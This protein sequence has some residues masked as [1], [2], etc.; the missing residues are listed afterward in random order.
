M[1]KYS[2]KRPFTVLVAVLIISILGFVAVSGMPADLLPPISLPY[3][4]VI[5]PYP[6]A[7]C[8]RV[9]QFVAQ[10]MER[11]LGTISGVKNIYSNCSENYCVIQLELED[12]VDMDASMVKISGAV[13]Q[14]EATLPDECGTPSILE[15]SMDMLATMYVA[16]SREGYDIYELSAFAEQTFAPY[17][18]RTQGVA[19]VTAIGLVEKSV[20]VDLDA[21]KVREVN[22]RVHRDMEQTLKETGDKLDEALEKVEDGQRSLEWQERNF[23][24]TLAGAITEQ[25]GEPVAQ[26]QSELVNGIRR[27]IEALDRTEVAIDDA[28]SADMRGTARGTLQETLELLA[29]AAAGD[30]VAL[31]E[32]MTRLQI[33]TEQVRAFNE[34]IEQQ[35]EYGIRQLP[36]RFEE[37]RSA[38]R[39]L[40]GTT[41]RIPEA[42][43]SAATITGALTQGQLDAAVGFST[44]LSQMTQLQQ[45]LKNA[46]AQYESAREQ[47][48]DNANV[49]GLINVQ[50]LSQIL[51]AQNFSMPAGYIDDKNDHSWLLKVGTEFENEKEIGDLLLVDAEGIGQIRLRDVAQVTVIDN[52]DLSYTRLNGQE[53]VALSIYKSSVAGTNEV[54]RALRKA[55]A[56]FERSYPG[57]HVVNLMDQGSYIDLIVADILKS[58]GFG[59]I[60]AIIVLA[61]FLRDVRPT[62]MVAVSIPLSVL[63]TMVLMYF[64]NLSLNIMTLSGISLGIGMLVDNSIVVMENII[65]LR[66]RGLGAAT[67]AVQGARQVF[68]A[69][70]ASTLTTVCVFV[71]MVFATG[72]VRSLLIPMALSITYCLTASLL[73]AMT[74][75]PA[76]ASVIM[77]RE[78]NGKETLFDKVKNAYAKSLRFCLRVKAIPLML[79]VGLLAFSVAAV[80]RM[81]IIMIPEITSDEIQ[82]DYTTPQGLTREESFAAVDELMEELMKIDGIQDIGFLDSS[83]GTAFFSSAA[84]RSGSYGTYLGYITT[85]EGLDTKEIARIVKEIEDT[86]AHMSGSVN[87]ETGGAG[88]IGSFTSS[89]LTISVYGIELDELYRIAKETAACVERIKGFEDIHDG[90]GNDEKA[91]QLVIDRDKAM[92]CGLTVAQ[93]Y[94]QIASRMQT[95]ADATTISSDNLT[96]TVRVNDE[97]NPLSRENLLDMEFESADVPGG[98]AAYG[99][100]GQS[101]SL[102]AFDGLFEEAEEKEEDADGEAGEAENKAAVHKLSEFASLRETTSPARIVRKNQTRYLTVSAR[103]GEGYNTTLLSRELEKELEQLNASLPNGYSVEMEGEILE[104]AEMIAQMTKLLLLAFLFIYLVMVAQFQ[105]LLSPFIIIFT[106]PLAF[107]GGMI[108]LLLFREQLSVLSLMG[109]LVLMGTVVNN[110]IVYVDYANQLR[111]GG[112]KRRD[113]L[114]ATGKT[115]MRPIIMTALTTVLA[116]TQL[117]FGTGMGAQLSRGMAIVIAGGLVYA[118]FMTLYIVPVMYDILFRR[119]PLD[120]NIHEDLDKIPDDAAAYLAE[121]KAKSDE[122][123][124]IDGFDGKA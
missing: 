10:P 122:L 5:T 31:M 2:V 43:S 34:R 75:V 113:A 58:M 54:S 74:V 87:V 57:T 37:S 44:A 46:Q 90:T 32:V 91:L 82:I 16:L 114:V 68:G 48:L 17:L 4:I 73:V 28:L 18:E 99:A 55:I 53:G 15:I 110:G 8:E 11:A 61:L 78:R 23:G 70:T 84:S 3:M 101:A 107:T 92:S 14:V 69:I 9:E 108:G 118:T 124:F 1:E 45:T 94:A 24:S 71:P 111:I 79:A 26:V 12:D 30:I 119:Q 83:S 63:F 25:S 76:S 51:Y 104:V 88:D 96:L 80:V 39:E 36:E 72:T 112:L 66:Q 123:E 56:D 35:A 21:K 115:R 47:A 109:F 105:S 41:E 103:T 121:Q 67:A 20:Q 102:D 27:M 97:T 49:D 89:G 29:K 13:T 93:I 77:R 62:V 117:I 98:S 60:L 6:G 85:K 86:T 52:A 19:N 116:M 64:S 95:S 42:V 65:R 59:A 81:G 38:L 7:S 33:A 50:N 22:R 100:G 120:V 40:E 106:I